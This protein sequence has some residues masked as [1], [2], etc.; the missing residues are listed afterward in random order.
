[1]EEQL[2][3]LGANFVVI[4]RGSRSMYDAW[5][6]PAEELARMPTQFFIEL[7]FVAITF[8][9]PNTGFDE[10]VT[11]FGAPSKPSVSS[12]SFFSYD[13]FDD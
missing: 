12:M 11:Q 2:L 3:G 5:L 13:F 1:M 4:G 6:K 8:Y 10:L 7:T 9:I